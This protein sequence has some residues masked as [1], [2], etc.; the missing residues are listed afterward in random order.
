MIPDGFQRAAKSRPCP[1]CGKPDWCLIAKDG[2]RAI[3]PRVISAQPWGEA[4]FMHVV[5]VLAGEL[6]RRPSWKNPVEPAIDADRIF[7]KMEEDLSDTRLFS[8]SKD[9]GLDWT[10][11]ASIGVGLDTASDSLAFPMRSPLGT[12]VGIRIRATDGRK[13]A[14]RGSHNGLFF[15]P[16]AAANDFAMVCEGPTDTAAMLGLGYFALGRSSCR[17]EAE[18]LASWFSHHK[19]GAVVLSDADGPG[20]EGAE[21]LADRLVGNARWVK[22]VEPTQGAKDARE[23]VRL[24]ATQRVVDR[25][26]SMASAWTRRGK[27]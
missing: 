1:V 4:G 14:V 17:G 12:I 7:K 25:A 24:G 8:E 10:S 6:V 18:E 15:D 9:L 16:H 5:G 13:W 21:H 2:S 19:V 20:V 22:V 23:W 3:C 11:L 26:V 27:V